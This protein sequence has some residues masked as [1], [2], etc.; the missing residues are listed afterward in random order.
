MHEFFIDINQ[1]IMKSKFVLAI[2]TLALLTACGGPS[3]LTLSS[4]AFQ[5][6]EVLPQNYS[7]DGGEVSPELSISG[8][9]EGT[10][11]LALVVEDPDTFA[12]TFTHWVVFDI[13]PTIETIAEDLAPDGSIVGNNSNNESMYYPACPPDDEDAHRYIFKLYALDI[14]LN[15]DQTLSGDAFYEAIE[16]RV[17]EQAELMA[18][19][20]RS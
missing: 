7:C 4:P 6:G 19:Y 2:L 3:V 12:G 20:S 11:S 15:G 16:G 9:P 1:Y 17:L 10:V 18:T 13:D 8:V 5:N 14:M